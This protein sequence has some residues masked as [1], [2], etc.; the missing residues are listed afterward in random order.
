MNVLEADSLSKKYGDE[1]ALDKVT[2]SLKAGRIYGLIGQNGAGKTTLMR[3]IAGLSFPSEGEL[4]LSGNRGE[5]DLR[6]ARKRIGFL[7]ESPGIHPSLTAKD[8]LV[9]QRTIRGIPNKKWEDE[10][11]SLVGL[12]A[13]SNK[14]TKNFSLGMKQRLGLALALVSNPDF[15]VLD[16][17]INGLDPVGVVEM[18]QVLLKLS[19][20]RGTCILL[21]SHN[22][23]ELYQLATDYILIDRGVVKQTISADELEKQCRQYV[24]I[25]V[26]KPELLASL[27][28]SE[29]YINDFT[30]ADDRSICVYDV[31]ERMGEIAEVI[32]K[33]DLLATNLSLEG[34]TL[35]KYYLK[36]IGGDVK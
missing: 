27:L 32:R 8:N 30:I 24:R 11:L 22:L 35:E 16:E 2:L 10:V 33:T 5:E 7:I 3:L 19:E 15:L 20:E 25:V 17:P 29:L 12:E 28:E 6:E 14:K 23:P 31:P 26:D 4:A 1:C 36:V 18:R 34:D 21:S 9:L 13:A